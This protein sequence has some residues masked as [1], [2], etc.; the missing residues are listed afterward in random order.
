MLILEIK[1]RAFVKEDS[2]A[3]EL[4]K[5]AEFRAYWGLSRTDLDPE[6]VFNNDDL[7]EVIKWARS[8]IGGFYLLL[9]ATGAVMGEV[10]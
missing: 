7:F 4:E 6:I 1:S 2:Q 3:P 10:S 5:I 8:R 9:D